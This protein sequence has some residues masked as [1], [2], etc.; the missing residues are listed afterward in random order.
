MKKETADG[1]WDDF[2]TGLHPPFTSSSLLSL[3]PSL[4]FFLLFCN[5]WDPRL[6][7]LGLKIRLSQSLRCGSGVFV[8]VW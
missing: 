5:S 8:F 1:R 2:K 7:A 6:S 3:F 4:S